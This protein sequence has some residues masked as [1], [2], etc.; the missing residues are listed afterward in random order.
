MAGEAL[1]PAVSS[2]ADLRMKARTDPR[3][4]KL[5]M[6]A[7]SNLGGQSETLDG[8]LRTLELN[9]AETDEDGVVGEINYCRDLVQ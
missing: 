1:I 8:A 9:A 4:A 3:Y 7:A 6:V 2:I 5:A